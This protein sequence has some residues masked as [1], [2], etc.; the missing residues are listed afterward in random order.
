MLIN[1]NF[2]ETGT[3][4]NAP[5][6]RYGNDNFRFRMYINDGGNFEFDAK[7]L[8]KSSKGRRSQLMIGSFVT[9]YGLITPS[10]ACLF[11]A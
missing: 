3:Y 1:A 8:N 11:D 7:I 9:F 5:Y 10:N 4:N 6:M 2:Y